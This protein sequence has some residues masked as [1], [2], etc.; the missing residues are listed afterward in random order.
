MLTIQLIGGTFFV[1]PDE[2]FG[3]G[4]ITWMPPNMKRAGPLVPFLIAVYYFL[5]FGRYGFSDTDEGFITGFAWR[6]VG[7][8]RIYR[9]FIYI[10]PPLTPLLHAGLMRLVPV[11]YYVLSERVLFYVLV[12]FYSYLGMSALRR[13]FPDDAG[14]REQG[15]L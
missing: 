5:L 15:W 4:K 11:D 9:D 14:L 6:I 3:P 1:S 2:F 10:R 13:I 12:L 7:G 8:E